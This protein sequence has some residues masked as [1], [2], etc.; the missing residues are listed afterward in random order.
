MASTTTVETPAAAPAV[1]SP[2][3]VRYQP[4][5]GSPDACCLYL[6]MG[7]LPHAL[8]DY[9]TRKADL[10]LL[11]LPSGF[12]FI[13]GTA[14]NNLSGLVPACLPLVTTGIFLG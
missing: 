3:L 1:E 6:R 11:R 4:L 7:S 5:L 8:A 14:R 9:T 2:N 10:P 13:G 12:V